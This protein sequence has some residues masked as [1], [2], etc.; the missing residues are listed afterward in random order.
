MGLLDICSTI[1]DCF[2]QLKE[3]IH[4]A[5]SVIRRKGADTEFT[6]EYGKYLASR[7]KMKAIQKASGN[8][9]GMKNELMVSSS[10]NDNESLSILDMLKEA[11]AVTVRSL[12]SLLMFVSDSRDNQSREDGQ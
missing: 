6:V 12:E 9:K 7:N 11:E 8:L 5:Q 3:N 1:Q 2:F 10:N 4:M